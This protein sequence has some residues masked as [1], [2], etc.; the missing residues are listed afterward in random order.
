M[1][2]YI[3]YL[4]LGLICW[5]IGHGKEG[6]RAVDLAPWDTADQDS[7]KKILES[8]AE[9]NRPKQVGEYY[10]ITV[11]DTL[12][13]AER[14]RLGINHFVGLISP[15]D[16]YEMYW[17]SQP[18]G[19]AKEVLD[20]AGYDQ[21]P[22]YRII[23]VHPPVLN[24]WWSMLHA[25]QPKCMEAMAM[26]RLMSGS[27]QD[28]GLEA[29]MLQMMAGQ[30]QDG[31]YWVPDDPRKTWL[32]DP[33]FRPHAN[34]H[35]QGR[36]L[37]AMV[38]WY[39]YTGNPLWKD[40]VDQMVDGLD[41][42]AVHKEDYAYFPTCGYIPHEYFRS[43][44]VK[45]LGWKDTREPQNEKD[46][47][48]GSLFNHQGH[49]PGVMANWYRLTGNKQAL[50]LAGELVRFY[51]KPQFWAD[52]E[53]GEYPG[54]IG[55]EHAH[56]R[57][58]LHGHVNVLRAI[59][60]YAIATNDS[61]LKLFVREGYE[62]ARQ[63]GIAR[64]G[65]VGDGQGCGCGRLIGLA[66]KLSRAGVGDYWEDI[67]LYIR[68]NGVEMQLT[69]EDIPYIR[70][71]IEGKPAPANRPWHG[72]DGMTA[73]IG[74][75]SNHVS[76]YKTSTSG[77]CSPHGNMG[78]FY[79]W[80]GMLEYEEGVTRINLLVNRASPWVDIDSYLPYKGKV[81]LRNKTAREAFVRIPLWVEHTKVTCQVQNREIKPRWFGNYLWLEQL[82]PGDTV[83][84]SFPMAE[85][86]EEWT[87]TPATAYTLEIGAGRT[88]RCTFR[89][90]TVVKITPEMSPG[91]W[92][93]KNREKK[94]QA[95]EAQ[96]KRV[97]R[98]VTEEQLVW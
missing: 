46:G 98:Y 60:E 86:V 18:L 12:D 11:P 24:F 77:C 13:L 81:V 66:V 87:I 61:R 26:E 62:W 59:L 78:L 4:G 74:G 41:R 25:C 95:A 27:T 52:W 75:Y 23:D 16:N 34:M 54:V 36:M 80:D 96:M 1:R 30:V 8:T 56:W 10:W 71:E 2:N 35:G 15:E 39:Q 82:V 53:K 73:N 45:G 63:S 68:N 17:G 84:I 3:R 43:S 47:E 85:R 20:Y 79:A 51:T 29:K 14:A 70:K 58:H 94:Y 49:M 28:L 42:I 55:S 50:R 88:Y 72:G 38:A 33:K 83:V 5:G 90:N 44:Y 67:D 19:F 22:G 97:K 48:E 6:A 31:L 21:V 64:L 57:G 76:P 32:G 93:W 40:L 91:S 89:G 9:I 37:R 92:I 65:I 7:A 69:P